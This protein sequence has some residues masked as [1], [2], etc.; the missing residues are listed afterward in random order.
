MVIDTIWCTKI[1]QERDRYIELCENHTD[2]F[3]QL[4]QVVNNMFSSKTE[5]EVFHVLNNVFQQN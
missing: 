4:M 3:E 2:K 1:D 5:A